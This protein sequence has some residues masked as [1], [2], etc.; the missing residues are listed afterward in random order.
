[1]LKLPKRLLQVVSLQPSEAFGG[2]L[3]G[4][5]G[6]A[7]GHGRRAPALH[8]ASDTPHRG[9]HILDNVGTERRSSFGKPNR[10]T[11]RIS[12]IPSRIEPDTPDQ[13]RSRRW[14]RLCQHR[15]APMLVATHAGLKSLGGTVFI[16]LPFPSWN[17]VAGGGLS[18]ANLAL[19]LRNS[20][21]LRSE[22]GVPCPI[23]C[24]LR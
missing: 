7:K 11:V 16:T 8:V 10:V 6:P 23:F 13:S 24:M 20:A 1:M 5:C 2:F 15:P 18:V 9:H 21:M 14:A 12:S 4:G 19:P 17:A 3:H 22:K